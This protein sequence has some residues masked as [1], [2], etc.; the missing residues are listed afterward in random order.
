MAAAVSTQSSIHPIKVLKCVLLTYFNI[1]KY[2]NATQ[3]NFGRHENVVEQLC[4]IWC[5]KYENKMVE[6]EAQ[7]IVLVGGY[8]NNDG[9]VGTHA[10]SVMLS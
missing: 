5:V 10:G 2:V 8:G 9:D 4:L 3:K 7:W 1:Y 6:V